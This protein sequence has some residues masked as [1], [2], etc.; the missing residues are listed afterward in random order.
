MGLVCLII[1]ETRSNQLIVGL[2]EYIEIMQIL[3]YVHKELRNLL[4]ASIELYNPHNK[5]NAID[6]IPSISI[7]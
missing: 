4:K 7:N 1:I 3:A 6:P 5:L 2:R